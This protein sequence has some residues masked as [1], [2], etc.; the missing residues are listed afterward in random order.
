MVLVI[1]PPFLAPCLVEEDMLSS[2]LNSV[3]SVTMRMDRG[4]L[5]VIGLA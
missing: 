3:A 5:G 1:P 4:D 2:E